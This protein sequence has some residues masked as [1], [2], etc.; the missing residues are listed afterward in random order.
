[1]PASLYAKQQC[2]GGIERR[3]IKT[4][5]FVFAMIA[6]RIVRCAIHDLVPVCGVSRS[7]P[8]SIPCRRSGQRGAER[9][10][11]NLG[12]Y[13]GRRKNKISAKVPKGRAPIPETA[14]SQGTRSWPTE[15]RPRLCSPTETRPAATVRALTHALAGQTG[16]RH[17]LEMSPWPR[18]LDG[19]PIRRRPSPFRGRCPGRVSFY[20]R[21]SSE[22]WSARVLPPA[23]RAMGKCIAN[24]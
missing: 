17:R 10:S 2:I 5:I 19:R 9:F 8:G 13:S 4:I 21:P 1:M 24:R 7:L 11:G 12:N 16:G 6:M 20:S 18:R 15:K 22:R 23:R 3:C 14:L